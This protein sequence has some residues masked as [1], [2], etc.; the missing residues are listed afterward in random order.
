MNSNSEN[1]QNLIFLLLGFLFIVISSISFD[2]YVNK[3]RV[4]SYE[5]DD[6]FSYLGYIY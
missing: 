4:I 5:P 3:D 1:K 6:I 2:Y